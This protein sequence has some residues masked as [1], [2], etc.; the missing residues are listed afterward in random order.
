MHGGGG[1]G[2]LRQLYTRAQKNF[3]DLTPYLTYDSQLVVST[4]FIHRKYLLDDL[5]VFNSHLPRDWIAVFTL[6]IL[7]P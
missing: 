3:T 4:T 2:G 5:W 7:K 6:K 1:G